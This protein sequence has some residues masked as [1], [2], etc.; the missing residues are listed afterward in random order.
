MCGKAVGRHGVMQGVGL[1]SWNHYLLVRILFMPWRNFDQQC[2]L[3]WRSQ[4]ALYEYHERCQKPFVH[5][6]SAFVAIRE[7]YES[8]RGPSKYAMFKRCV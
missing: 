6:A 1:K 7:P 4:D 2:G 3:L 8:A 5:T